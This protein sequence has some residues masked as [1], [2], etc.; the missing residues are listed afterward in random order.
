MHRGLDEMSS[1]SSAQCCALGQGSAE[2][3]RTEKDEL[4]VKETDDRCSSQGNRLSVVLSSRS[5][6]LAPIRRYLRNNS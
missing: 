6:G 3:L 4:L 1:R 2:E 5:P